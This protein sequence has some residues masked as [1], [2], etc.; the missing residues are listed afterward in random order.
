MANPPLA[1][2]SGLA[3]DTLFDSAATLGL[4]RG[5]GHDAISGATNEGKHQG[6]ATIPSAVMAVDTDADDILVAEL[7]AVAL[8]RNYLSGFSITG[9]GATAASV[10][11]AVIT[12]TVA[13][14]NI[15]IPVPTGVDLGIE[16][17][18]VTLASPIPASAVN[19]A[20]VLT[21]PS[22]GSGNTVASC[23]VWGYVSA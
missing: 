23:A 1:Q 19:T 10:I 12:G 11:T 7:P 20:I 6:V 4:K 22:F 18:I 14:W 3:I 13:T 15:D 16:P 9:G 8:K 17:I 21:V 5:Y 2:S